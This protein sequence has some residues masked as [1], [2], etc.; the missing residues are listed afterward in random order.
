VQTRGLQFLL[1]DAASETVVA[2]GRTIPFVW[3]GSLT[4]LPTG[5]DAV[6]LAPLS[7]HD[8]V[9]QYWEPN[10]WMLHSLGAA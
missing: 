6:G 8:G 5:I 1:L 9:G 10:V 2:G 3:D 4:D 7:V